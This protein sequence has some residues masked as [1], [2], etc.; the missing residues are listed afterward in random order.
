MPNKTSKDKTG[1]D[2][3]ERE[4]KF[5]TKMMER[6]MRGDKEGVTYEDLR[7]ELNI[8]Q[9]VKSQMDAWKNLMKLGYIDA[10]NGKKYTLTAMAVDLVASPEYKEYIKDLNIVSATNE[11]HQNRIKKHLSPK[12]KKQAVQIFDFLQIYGSLTAQE[13]AALC[14]TKRGSH[15]FSYG[16]QELKNKKYVEDN[17]NANRKVKGKMLRL[18]DK[19][20]LTA[21][22]RP[23]PE[24]IDIEELAKAVELNQNRKRGTST[25]DDDNSKKDTKK[26]KNKKIK[27]ES[28]KEEIKSSGV[29]NKNDDDSD[30]GE[31]DD[32]SDHVKSEAE[33]GPTVNQKA[34]AFKKQQDEEEEDGNSDN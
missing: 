8:G 32:S 30:E 10:K 2:L 34:A 23:E 11:D 13:L 21:A 24:Q 31:N 1:P 16:L 6:E 25:K 12:F 29:T 7:V 20:F 5:L 19:A 22:D 17:P 18:A 15:G 28:D 33:E 14:H 4:I 26:S 9:R 27:S 3:P